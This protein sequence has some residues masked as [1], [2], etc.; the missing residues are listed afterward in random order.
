MNNTSVQM[1]AIMKRIFRQCVKQEIC[2]RAQ[3][4]SGDKMK[5]SGVDSLSRW[6]EFEV[7]AAVFKSFNEHPKWGGFGGASGYTVDLYASTQSAK[8]ER[9]CAR[10]GAVACEVQWPPVSPTASAV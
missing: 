7:N 3:H 6:G 2:L 9:Y 4:L 1:T 5:E 10:G 8:C